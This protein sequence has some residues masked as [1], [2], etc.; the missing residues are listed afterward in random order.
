MTLGTTSPNELEISYHGPALSSG[1]MNVRDLAPAMMAVGSLLES[2]NEL[3]NGDRAAID[4]RVNATSSASFHI[5]FEILQN[6]NVNSFSDIIST[7]NEIV[8]LIIGTG[9]VGVGLIAVIKWLRG[10]NPKVEQIN[11]EMYRL[12][13]ENNESY[14]VPL[15]LLK[16]YQNGKVR[17]ALTNMVRPIQ[18]EGIESFQ[19]RKNDQ[20]VA[21][22]EEDEWDYFDLPETQ[23]IILDE[24]R[25][26]VFTIV[27]L[28]F[29]RGNKW[30]LTDGELT[31]SVSMRDGEFQDRVDN[32]HAD[33]AKDDVLVCD[34]RTI[35]T[36]TPKGIKT[37]YEIIKVIKHV[38][39]RQTRFT[40]L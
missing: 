39:I 28:A 4:I 34:L 3:L 35:Q 12:T 29:R 22:V 10:R 19:I 7:A 23:E 31:Y 16:M 40:G 8:N 5:L 32:N 30:R 17:S 6:S 21:S 11:E 15:E 33:F 20:L 14:E 1:Q 25:N 24:I 18:V 27:N 13:L 36:M 2:A 37:D 9:V 38:P 26:H